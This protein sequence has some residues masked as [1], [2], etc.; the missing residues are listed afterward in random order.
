MTAGQHATAVITHVDGGNPAWQAAWRGVYVVG[1]RW[2]RIMRWLARMGVPTFANQLVELDLVGRRTGRPRRVTVTLLRLGDR[3]Y[4]GHP[5]GPRSWLANLGAAD[6]VD[7]IVVGQPPVR[8]RPVPLGLG[9]ERDA[10]IVATAWQ[11]PVGAREWYRV[12]QGHIRRAGIYYRLEPVR[13]EAS[14]ASPATRVG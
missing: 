1:R 2:G 10:V 13:P 4:V 11:Q 12:A 6:S 7:A 5:N 8:V 9:P 3:W 14:G